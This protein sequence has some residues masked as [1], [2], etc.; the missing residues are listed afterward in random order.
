MVNSDKK[1]SVLIIGCGLIGGSLDML[2]NS[3]NPPLTHAGAFYKDTRFYIKG[4]VDIDE[5]RRNEFSKHWNIPDSYKSLDEVLNKES[6][7][8]L[9]SVCTP[10]DTHFEILKDILKLSPKLVLAEKPLTNNISLS[11]T[12]SDIYKKRDIPLV[13]NLSRRW[14]NK[15]ENFR[16]LIETKKWGVLRSVNAIYNKGLMNNGIHVIDLLYML[17]ENIN[18]VFSGS[19]I[20]DYFENDPSIPFFLE[21]DNKVPILVNC[22]Y[23]KDYSMFEFQLIFSNAVISIENGGSSWR[24]RYVRDSDMFFGYK[25]LDGGVFEISNNSQTFSNLVN[26]IYEHIKFKRPLK[27][28][29][30]S[31]L[32]SQKLCEKI[33]KYNLTKGI[34]NNE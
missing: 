2:G 23:A 9:I 32:K 33:K 17:L 30:E 14:D 26:N 7:Y 18:F 4:C 8:D 1:I 24:E 6:K 21:T 13:V 5:N 19:P 25:I 12:I 29:L 15:I 16:S 3:N 28:T 22:A 34:N 31:A 11:E 10:T 20:N 27:N